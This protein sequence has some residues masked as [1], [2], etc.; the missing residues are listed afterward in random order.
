MKAES[1]ILLFLL[2]YKFGLLSEVLTSLLNAIFWSKTADL[3]TQWISADAD[4]V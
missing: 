3:I 4:A 1:N 2:K